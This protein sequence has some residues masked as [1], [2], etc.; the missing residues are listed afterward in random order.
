MGGTER[1]LIDKMNWLSFHGYNVV[2][3]TYEQGKH[4]FIYELSD[5]VRHVD[6]N[7]CFYKLYKYNPI[8][9]TYKEWR[10]SRL[11]CKR[12]NAFM[13]EYKPDIVI[14]TTNC[15]FATSSAIAKSSFRCKKLLES[16]IDKRYLLNNAII[17][18][19]KV[20]K[21][22]HSHWESRKRLR[23]AKFFDL[24]I[25]LNQTDSDDWAPYVKTKVITNMVH[26]NE[27]GR[28]SDGN[29]KHVIF[30]GRYVEQKA[31]FD[32]LAIWKLVYEKHPDWHLDLYGDG[33]YRDL[34]VAEAERLQANI[35]IYEPSANIFDR[36]K[37][38]SILLLTSIYEPFGLVLP[39][40]MSCGLPVVSFEADGP[41]KI[42]TDGVDGF[43]VK[44][45][46][47]NEFAS[48]V[49]QLIEDEGLRKQM[50]QNAIKSAQ[51]YS[52]D[53]IMPQ[54]VELF[55]SLKQ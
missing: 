9:R 40:A 13:E 2:A 42:I 46:N 50:G 28:Y 39:E 15:I 33:E 7:V 10:M 32:L 36:Y 17:N 34:L 53:R 23:D 5:K 1:I 55:E 31:P 3:L 35:H 44:N 21:L 20:L 6:L 45:R 19:T 30:A 4:P 51:R 49:C 37:E 26:L 8:I 16:H 47:A 54:W 52:A 38:S 14:T 27:D 41:C 18:K 11:L 22:I 29:S 25:A 12:F 24:L 48:R 43:L